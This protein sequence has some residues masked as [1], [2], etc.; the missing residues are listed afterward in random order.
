MYFIPSSNTLHMADKEH[1]LI[2][3]PVINPEAN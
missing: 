2:A 3:Q 1:G